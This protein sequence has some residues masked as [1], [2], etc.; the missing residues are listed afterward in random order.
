[1]STLDILSQLKWKAHQKVF[2]IGIIGDSFP[3][4]ENET[5]WVDHKKVKFDVSL[6]EIY[7]FTSTF[8]NI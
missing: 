5:S 2:V 3:L 6:E 4:E 1:V 8:I 7:F